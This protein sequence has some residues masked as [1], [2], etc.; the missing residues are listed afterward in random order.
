MF[1]T[2]I[3]EGLPMATNAKKRVFVG[4]DEGVYPPVSD[5][6]HDVSATF[7]RSSGEAYLRS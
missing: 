7:L 3:K 5:I 4:P 2:L 6:L 1:T